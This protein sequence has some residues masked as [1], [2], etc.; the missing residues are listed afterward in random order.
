MAQTKRKRKTKHRGT[1]AGNVVARG[2]TSRPGASAKSSKQTSR[3]RQQAR[4]ARASQPPTW[5]G[6]TWR[7]AVAAAIFFIVMVILKQPIA[8]AAFVTVLMFVLYIPMGFYTD[9]F[10]YGRRQARLAREAA[11]KREA[12]ER[13]S[14]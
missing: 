5:K 8:S 1:P 3:Q 9:K 11:A 2:R 6:A 7:A 13:D 4:A 14:Q 10:L 12:K